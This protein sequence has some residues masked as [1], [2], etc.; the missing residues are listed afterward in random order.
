MPKFRDA[1]LLCCWSL[2]YP[3]SQCIHSQNLVRKGAVR[4]SKQKGIEQSLVSTLS[5][6]MYRLLIV[7]LSVHCIVLFCYDVW[8]K[9]LNP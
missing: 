9:S 1:V 5:N 2:H 8:V 3:S 7:T 6:K 4:G